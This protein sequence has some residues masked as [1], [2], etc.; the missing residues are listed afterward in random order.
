[1]TSKLLTN[2]LK[3]PTELSRMS[4]NFSDVMT[5]EVCCRWTAT[6]Q[7]T[8]RVALPPISNNQNIIQV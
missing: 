6:L 1:M 4:E 5:H 8:L 2:F 7:L 3:Y